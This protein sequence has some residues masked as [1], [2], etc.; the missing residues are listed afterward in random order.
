MFPEGGREGGP[1]DSFRH[2]AM[3]RTGFGRGDTSALQIPR[4]LLPN[5]FLL[6]VPFHDPRRPSSSSAAHHPPIPRP[7]LPQHFLNNPRQSPH[8]LALLLPPYSAPPFAPPCF[9]HVPTER[10]AGSGHR[11]IQPVHHKEVK[12]PGDMVLHPILRGPLYHGPPGAPGAD[13]ASS[14]GY[15]T[16]S[17]VSSDPRT[18]PPGGTGM[19]LQFSPLPVPSALIG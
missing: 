1:P 9:H 19:I 7:L 3:G 16:M 17:S 18:N 13:G 4:S 8:H 15:G 5:P 11:S 2:P 6:L 12:S 14:A 10:F